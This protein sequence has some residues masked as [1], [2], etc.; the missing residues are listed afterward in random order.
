MGVRVSIRVEYP[1]GRAVAGAEIVAVNHDA[2]SKRHQ[3]WA[4]TSGTTGTFAWQ[5]LD[6]GTRGDRYTFSVHHVDGAG[7]AWKGEVSERIRTNRD[8]LVV[9]R[10]VGGPVGTGVANRRLAAVMFTDVAGFTRAAQV[11]EARA[12]ELLERHRQLLRPLFGRHRGTEIKTMGDGF[13]VEF[14]STLEASRCAL[15]IQKVLAEY[16]RSAGDSSAIHVR[17]GIHVGDV[18][19]DG[20]DI[21]GDA[22][23][24]A[25]RVL[26]LAEPGGI[27]VSEDV[28]AQVRNRL[29]VPF[30]PVDPV[31]MKS[32]VFPIRIYKMLLRDGPETPARAAPRAGPEGST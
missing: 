20:G 14:D 11:D 10:K 22:V 4:G 30:V 24:L 31:G 18:V 23:N 16:N 28:Y 17:I 21:L 8:L 5:N 6:K 32:T 25:S 29:G 13:L 15:D 1:D 9:L 19:H 7:V 2:W 26:P 12:L 27:C 3:T